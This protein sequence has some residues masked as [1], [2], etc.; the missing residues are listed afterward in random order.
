MH[1]AGEKHPP[2]REPPL[3]SKGGQPRLEK[4][5]SFMGRKALDPETGSLKKGAS[6]RPPGSLTRA[7]S[8]APLLELI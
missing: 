3:G 5:K 1:G 8:D 7:H 2:L 6:Q 4:E